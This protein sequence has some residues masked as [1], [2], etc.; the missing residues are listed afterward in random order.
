LYI[1]AEPAG[2]G[3]LNKKRVKN[4]MYADQ[5]MCYKMVQRRQK[6]ICRSM[7]VS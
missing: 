5:K 2:I 7:G 1:M 3:L 4:L 6:R